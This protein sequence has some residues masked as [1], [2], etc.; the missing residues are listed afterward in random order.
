MS[1]NWREM[2]LG[3]FIELKRG[4]DLPKSKRVDG[5]VEIISSSGSSGVHNESKVKAPGVVTGRYGTIGKVFFSEADFWPLNTTLY[6]KD[7]KGNDPLF[8]FYFLKTINYL[9][10]SDKAAVP[11][12]NRNHIHKAKIRVPDC[13]D[14]QNKLALRLWAIDKKIKINQEINLTL[15]QIAQAIFKSWFVDFEPTKAKIAAREA[16]LADYAKEPLSPNTAQMAKAPFAEEIIKAER[17]AAMQSIAGSGD[18]VPTEQ[19][20]TL[21]D[22]FPNK[23]VDSELGEIPE[24]WEASTLGQHFD[25]TMGQSPKGDTYNEKGDGIVFFQGRRDFG[26]RFPSPRVYTSDPKRIAEAG[27]TLIS[28]RAPVGDK[29]MA[30]ERCCL[31]RGVGGIRHKSDMTSFTYAFISVIEHKLGDSGSDG[32]VFNSINKNELNKVSFIAPS[33]ELIA[34]FETLVQPMDAR[35]KVNSNQI[36]TLEQLRDSLLP[37]LLSGEINLTN[38][39]KEA[40]SV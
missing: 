33:P 4:Y 29:N 17:Q 25:V 28:V 5:D 38:D 11:G 20:Q 16:L 26:F 30:Y 9:E 14:Y 2:E 24:Y 21:A 3:D 7:F 1:V 27:D 22:L 39:H 10:Y 36:N 32:T 13:P 8:V 31:G 12:I 34:V 35:I 6:V 37:K 23:L 19:L 15:E 40:V 18:I